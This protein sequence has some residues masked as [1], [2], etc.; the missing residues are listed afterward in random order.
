MVP[1]QTRCAPASEVCTCGVTWK[2]VDQYQPTL[3]PTLASI[4]YPNFTAGSRIRN[5]LHQTFS[6]SHRQSWES[7]L[8]DQTKKI[9][10]PEQSRQERVFEFSALCS[11]HLSILKPHVTSKK[12]N[13][14]VR[15]HC[16]YFRIYCEMYC[17]PKEV[18]LLFSFICFF[19]RDGPTDLLWSFNRVPRK[20]RQASTLKRRKATR[21][22]DRHK[23]H[24][25]CFADVFR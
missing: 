15:W 25:R 8:L 6:A 3:T 18:V 9:R 20:E 5:L 19:I 21:R 24:C 10:D 11:V 13:S 16:V 12:V 23:R 7:W 17:E 1:S 22:E 2:L 14:R 4:R